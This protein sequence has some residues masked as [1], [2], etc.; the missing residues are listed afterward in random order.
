M[1][2]YVW[3]EILNGDSQIKTGQNLRAKRGFQ[4]VMNS[5]AEYVLMGDFT[6]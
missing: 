6:K 3:P 1:S 2:K 4:R 5:M